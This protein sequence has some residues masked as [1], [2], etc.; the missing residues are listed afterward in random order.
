[1]NI[2]GRNLPACDTPM[3]EINE[4]Y[5][6]S[7]KPL[8]TYAAAALEGDIEYTISDIEYTISKRFCM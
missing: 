7:P 1:M 5:P 8:T 2:N 3:K 4:I 6:I